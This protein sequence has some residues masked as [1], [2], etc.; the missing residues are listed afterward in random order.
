MGEEFEG[1]DLSESVFWG[2]DLS[3]SLFRDAEFA[4][5]RFFHVSME[6]VDID[7]IV[8]R[9]MVN[10]VDVTSYV[11]EHDRWYPLRTMLSPSDAAGVATAWTELA[12]E[13]AVLDERASRMARD[14]L[15]ESVN[16]EWSY[17]DTLRHLV[18]AHDKWFEWPI[19]GERRFS[20]IGNPNTGSRD[21]EWPGLD[22]TLDPSLEEVRLVRDEYV[23]R[24]GGF[25]KTLDLA[26]LSDTVEVLENGTVPAIMCFHTVLEEEFEHLRYATRDLAILGTQGT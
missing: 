21:L 5:S 20:P 9:L 2:V 8:N 6:N 24:F 17:R 3:K 26:T 25:V 23:A 4:G 14:R 16:G 19:L 12:R 11:N 1:R 15:L 13:W 10:G 7:G 18:F 22:L